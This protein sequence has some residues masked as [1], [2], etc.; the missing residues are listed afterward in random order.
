LKAPAQHQPQPIIT[1]AEVAAIEARPYA[2]FMPHTRVAGALAAAAAAN[3]KRTALTYISSADPSAPV[4]RWTYE[5][6]ISQV[7]RAARLFSQLAGPDTPRVALLLPPLPQTHFALWGAEAVGVVC[8]INFL[9]NGEHIAELVNAA[10]A[11]IVLALGPHPDLEIADKATS[12]PARCPQLRHLLWVDAAYATASPAPTETVTVTTS[13]SASPSTSTS[14]R[15]STSF[16]TLLANTPDGPW[17]QAPSAQ[18][19]ALFHTGGT[20]GAP[21]LAQHTHANQL[22]AAWSA[23]QMF[24][25]TH[26]DVLINGFPLFHVAGAFVYGLSTLLAGG[27]LVLPTLLGMRNA[28]FVKRYWQHI[29]QHQVTLLT[30]VPTVMATLLSLDRGN[31]NINSVRALLTGG[32]PLP[33]ELALQFE[34]IHGVP[35]R[36]ILGMT[37]CAGVI[38]VEPF[39]AARTPGS[40]GLPLPFS[41][42]LAVADDGHVCGANEPGVLRLRGPNVG[43]GYTDAARNVGTFTADG[44]LITGDIGHVDEAGRVFVTGRAKDLIIRSG[45]NIDPALIEAV[46]LA[47]PA[48]QMAAAVGEPDAYAGELPVAYVVLKPGGNV[49]TEALLQFAQAHIAERPAWPKRVEILDALPLTAV[50]KIYKPTLRLRAMVQAISKLVDSAGLNS[51]LEVEGVDQGSQLKLLFKATTVKLQASDHES[52]RRLM[53]PFAIAHELLE[54]VP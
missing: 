47:H 23:S 32:S 10:G 30:A 11:N 36:N 31:A 51:R 20:T 12:L 25:M 45:H 29:E 33:N 40:C 13:A 7:R 28:A 27:H 6:F 18:V 14:A 37:E 17:P 15:A 53:A 42:V 52:I 19:V 3:A 9:L 48:V 41:Q 8:P 2:N 5:D 44:W 49:S 38:S 1:R 4:A 16:D 39:G 46:L 26:D 50:G 35:V 22:H 54:L 21:K 24:A 34:T 43:P